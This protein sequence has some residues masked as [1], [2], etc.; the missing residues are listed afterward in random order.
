V[1]EKYLKQMYV[2]REMFPETAE[3]EFIIPASF[4]SEVPV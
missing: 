3:P 4:A 1:D 2:F